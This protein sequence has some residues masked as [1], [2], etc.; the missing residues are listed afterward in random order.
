LA[1][2]NFSKGLKNFK[3]F[4]RSATSAALIG[5]QEGLEA[6]A[7]EFLSDCLNVYP[8][9]P[10]ATGALRDAHEWFVKRQGRWSYV[11]GV[12]VVGIPYAR[13]VH[14]GVSR[15][16]TPITYKTPG[17]GAKWIEIK[18]VTLAEKYYRTASRKVSD[19]L[20]RAFRR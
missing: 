3:K 8:K 20:R 10:Y 4:Q 7:K 5:S 13:V 17:T 12:R 18:Q 16:G 11:G 6:A 15:W 19:K 2:L 1:E 9:V 14:E